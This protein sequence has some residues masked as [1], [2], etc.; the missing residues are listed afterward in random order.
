M[1]KVKFFLLQVKENKLTCQP[2]SAP[3]KNL[4]I[5][6]VVII[7]K[8]YNANSGLVRGWHYMPSASGKKTQ[9]DP[10][11]TEGGVAF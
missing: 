1:S 2:I 5:H 10:I 11:R 6:S 8:I 4:T 9:N 3:L 7:L